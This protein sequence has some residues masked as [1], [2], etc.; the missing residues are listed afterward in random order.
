MSTFYH[1]LMAILILGEIISLIWVERTRW[2]V[3][4]DLER[5]DVG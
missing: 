4:R 2:L 3:A 5:S 1:V